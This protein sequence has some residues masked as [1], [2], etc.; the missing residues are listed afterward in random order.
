MRASDR[1]SCLALIFS[2]AFLASATFAQTN[3]TPPVGVPQKSVTMPIPMGFLDPLTGQVHIEMPIASIP[4]R[5]GDSLVVKLVYDPGWYAYNSN[6][7]ALSLV[8]RGWTLAYNLR[9][10]ATLQ[11]TVTN[12][13]NSCPTGYTNYENILQYTN[14]FVEDI[15]G[16]RFPISNATMSYEDCRNSAGQRYPYTGVNTL[17]GFDSSYFYYLNATINSSTGRFDDQI[18][19]Q[20]GTIAQ[21]TTGGFAGTTNGDTGGQF[22]TSPITFS[23]SGNGL[24]YPPCFLGAAP[25]YIYVV[26]SNGTKQTY[27]INCQTYSVAD[28]TGKQNTA[29]VVFPASLTLP[30][31]SSYSFGYDTGTTGH[32]PGTLTSLTLPTGGQLSLGWVDNSSVYVNLPADS[33]FF[34]QTVTFGGGT[35]NLTNTGTISTSVVTTVT[36]PPRYD[37]TAKAYV[38]DKSVYTSVA[39]PSQPIVLQS[40]QYYN[41]SSTL[42][43][44]VTFTYPGQY[45][46]GCLSSVTTTLNDTGQSS[47]VQ[48]QTPSGA[49]NLA[50][51]IQ[52]FDFGASTP[53]R[54]KKI[55]YIT[56]T[57]T[58]KYNSVYHI[59]NRPLNVSVY[60][61]SGSGSPTA[62]TTY[63]YDEYSANYCKNSVPM[64][65][66][67][68]G[69]TNHDDA[70][71]GVSFAARGNVTTTQRLVSGSTYSTSHS[72]YDTLGNLTQSVDSAGNPTTY[73]Y[74]DSGKWADSGCIPSGTNTHAFP[75]TI[76]DALGH[77]TKLTYFTCTSLVQS[78]RDQNDIN[79][80][81]AGTTYSYDMFGRTTAVTSSDG[82]QTT[83]CFTD[84]GG[85]TCRQ[86]APPFEQ[87]TT[88]AISSS[89]ST[90]TTTVF[91]SLG[92]TYIQ[93]TQQASGYDSVETDYDSVGR[94]IRVTLPYVGS[95]GQTNPNG[96]AITTAYDAVSRPQ[97]VQDSGGGFTSYLYTGNDVLVTTG[98]APNGENA[99]SRQLEHDALGR[100]T[101]VCELTAGSGS[102]TCGQTSPKTGYW[103]KY[104]NDANGNLT[105]VTQNAQSSS[106]IQMRNYAYD[107][108]SRL[109]SETNP[110]SGTTQYFWDAAPSA[111]GSGGWSTLGD[112]GA[113]KDN[114]GVYTCYGYD[115]LHR[116]GGFGSTN[117]SDCTG[118]AYDSATPPTGVSVQNTVG[119]LVEAYTNNACNGHASIVTDEWFGYDSVGRAQDQYQ[120]SPNSGGWYHANYLYYFNGAIKQ[121]SGLPTLPTFT[122][123]LDGEGRMSTLS[124]SA[125]PGQLNQNPLT[126][127]T[128]NAAS[129]PTALSF[130]SG[131]S[132]AFTYD[133]NTNRMTK[134]QFN[135]STQSYAATLG[136]NAN[137]TLASLGITDPF[138]SPDSQNCTY[139]HDDLSRILNVGCTPPGSN[140]PTVWQQSFSYDPF[141]NINKSGSMSFQPTYSSTTNQM[142]SLPGCSPTYDADGNV[143][144]NCAHTYTWNAQGNHITVDGL[145]LT[146]DAFG[147]AIEIA[148]PSEIFFLLDGSQ[149]LFKGQVARSAM[150]R[151]PGGAQVQYDSANGGLLY[152][153]HP[154]HLG[155]LRLISTPTRAFSSSLAY[156]PFGEQYALSNPNA[157]GEAAFTGYGS[158]FGFDEYDFPARQYS[159]EGRWV[160]PDPAGLA[161]VNPANPQSWNR[162]AYVLNN[163]LTYTDPDGLDCIYF[164]GGDSDPHQG[165]IKS[166]DCI[167][168]TDNG[169]YVDGSIYGARYTDANNTIDLSTAGIGFDQNNN[170]AGYAFAPYDTPLMTS[171][172]V[173]CIGDCP[174]GS[175]QVTA[176]PGTPTMSAASPPSPQWGISDW[177]K[178]NQTFVKVENIF[179]AFAGQDPETCGPMTSSEA[180]AQGI[181]HK[182]S[183]QTP[184][185]KM[186]NQGET[187]KDSSPKRPGP[188]PKYNPQGNLKAEAAIEWGNAPAYP[189]NLAACLGNAK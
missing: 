53:T 154:D 8:G 97:M 187:V 165:W 180:E 132:D 110:E 30:D 33:S 4:Q 45:G 172:G 109:T 151:L 188:S 24:P 41:G 164:T 99:K 11:Y 83:N 139:S 14:F 102:G 159:T 74:S 9:T 152:Y 176:P 2:L 20:D 61:G 125:I 78:Q 22:A 105:G 88:Q 87:V 177:G 111:C 145:G 21:D 91:D 121:V 114:A 38:N 175:V 57:S 34:P 107:S 146:F 59:Y 90:T 40:V 31:G 44:T 92:R 63:V 5:D 133:P 162:Y 100:L 127:T 64:L 157:G 179:G 118:F 70:G 68:T 144:N 1:S 169:Y 26:D 81:R 71:H 184:Q 142:I 185:Q 62:S 69:A 7:N 50:T 36:A 3:Y 93:Q 19:R 25:Y 55:S 15:N 104:V 35:W 113:K 174:S 119:R 148:Y 138:N 96:P 79:A 137:G 166:G 120:T 10:W 89:L 48:Y 131:D 42:L 73:D 173:Q 178:R 182:P 80:S 94:P 27:T 18:W 126:G 86:S 12:V 168:E 128:Y 116:L 29:S 124:A 117:S 161:A 129:L 77:Q 149:V 98:P 43:K 52:G 47:S 106:N 60:S 82:G 112:L 6:L 23:Q 160:S 135:I 155:S 28:G 156:A 134:Y 108:L 56:D 95:L 39:P 66:N 136:W 130:G 65:S 17:S 58:I 181:E 158:G 141:G 75:T 54:T 85:S 101:S 67:V 189:T 122:Y 123:G 153:A 72:C 84:I 163:P 183:E 171:A 49:C 16:T 143:L 150:F 147:Q 46:T 167:S 170:F 51:Q 37:A 32:H 140:T 13:Y 186:L 103:T 76:T 115:A